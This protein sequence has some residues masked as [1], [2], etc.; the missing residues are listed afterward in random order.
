MSRPRSPHSGDLDAVLRDDLALDQIGRGRRPRGADNGMQVLIAIAEDIEIKPPRRRTR[1]SRLTRGLIATTVAAT[2]LGATGVAAAEPGGTGSFAFWTPRPGN[3]VEA[4]DRSL[5]EAQRSLE[6]GDKATANRQL[7]KADEELRKAGSSTHSATLEERAEDLRG[8]A[9]PK[10]PRPLP[11]SQTADPNWS[12]LWGVPGGGPGWQPEESPYKKK[13][14]L[15]ICTK[16]TKQPTRP[17]QTPSTAEQQQDEEQTGI[18]FRRPTTATPNTPGPSGP[19]SSSSD[20]QP[21]LPTVSPSPSGGSSENSPSPS[22]E[23]TTDDSDSSPSQ[24][25]EPRPTASPSGS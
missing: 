21:G 3:H 22:E 15:V 1:G 20:A 2:V 16:E 25:Y 24:S 19:S 10:T 4:A 9:D 17:Q 6:R 12:W 14:L 18:L 8:E 5:K 23:Q 11:T 13:C 7:S